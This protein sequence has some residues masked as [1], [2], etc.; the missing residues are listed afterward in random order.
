MLALLLVGCATEAYTLVGFVEDTDVRI[1]IAVENDAA[2]L[3]AATMLRDYAP[4]TPIIAGVEVSTN[5]AR[6]RAAGADYAIA[7][8]NV[9]GRILAH[10]LL[11]RRRGDAG[12]VVQKRR[13]G[14][15]A[16]TPSSVASVLSRTGVVVL[17]RLESDAEDA[18]FQ[19]LGADAEVSNRDFVK[20]VASPATLRD[21]PG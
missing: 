12:Y 16:N 14:A 10:H 3:F 13:M 17:G 20:V 19:L 21:Y 2:T 18:A 15:L 1:G 4:N 6:T 5:V 9:T 11:E 8:D 7:L